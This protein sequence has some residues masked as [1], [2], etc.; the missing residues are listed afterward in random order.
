MYDEEGCLISETVVIDGTLIINTR[1]SFRSFVDI[2]HAIHALTEAH[3]QA[4]I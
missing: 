4:L 1:D 3:Q 2:L